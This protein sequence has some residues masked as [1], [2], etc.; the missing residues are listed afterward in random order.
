MSRQETNCHGN[1]ENCSDAHVIDAPHM[2]MT[3]IS[4]KLTSNNGNML[5]AGN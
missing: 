5:F 2:Y 1:W 3:P 4:N